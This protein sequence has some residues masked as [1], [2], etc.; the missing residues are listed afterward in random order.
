MKK[1]VL[2]FTLLFAG[3]TLAGCFQTGS[4]G[5]PTVGQPGIL[6]PL[7]DAGIIQQST[8]DKAAAVQAQA[9]AF[10]GY[11]PTLGTLLSLFS[12]GAAGGAV[13]IASGLCGAVTTA[14]L[15]DGGRRYAN[16]RAPNGQ[17][18]RLRG[19]LNGKRV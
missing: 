9:K 18:I 16:V 14:P 1:V 7:V 15:A 19:T 4:D 10:C 6:S 8:R 12:A 2:A 5:V 17:V 11:V 3:V 13:A